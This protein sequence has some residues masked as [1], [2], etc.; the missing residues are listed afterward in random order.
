MGFHKSVTLSSDIH[1]FV[2]VI[3]LTSPFRGL[4]LPE[5]LLGCSGNG[6]ELLLYTRLEHK[7]SGLLGLHKNQ[8]GKRISS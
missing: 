7:R 6:R 2:Y 4:H 8:R 5:E 1:F 3:L